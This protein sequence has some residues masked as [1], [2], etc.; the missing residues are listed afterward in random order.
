MTVGCREKFRQN[1][2]LAAALL[3]TG[4]TILVE[5]S[6]Y[7]RIWGVGLKWNDPRILDQ[8]LWL[9]TNLLGKALMKVRDVLA[10]EG[11]ELTFLSEQP[12]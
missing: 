6:P 8:S 5:A 12:Q 4:D 1:P 2:P 11:G 7:D 10:T 9:G 3:A